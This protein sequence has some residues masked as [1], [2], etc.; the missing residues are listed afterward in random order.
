MEFTLEVVKI[1]DEPV[2]INDW[3]DKAACNGA[4]DPE[5]FF[6]PFLQAKALDYCNYCPVIAECLIFAQSVDSDGLV[7]APHGVYGG[8]TAEQRREIRNHRRK[9]K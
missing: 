5:I 6:L 9:L 1:L 7:M 8:T 2:V 4:T 3:R